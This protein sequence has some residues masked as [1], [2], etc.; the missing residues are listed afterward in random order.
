MTWRQEEIDTNISNIS[1]ILE[2]TNLWISV[3]DNDTMTTKKTLKICHRSDE[4]FS[5]RVSAQNRGDGCNGGFYPKQ[6]LHCKEGAN[7]HPPDN[8]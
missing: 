7:R 2:E 6:I 5:E 1:R 8:T 3:M 4:I